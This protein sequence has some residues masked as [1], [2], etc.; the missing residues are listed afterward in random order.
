M[1]A[2]KRPLAP[3]TSPPWSTGG[4]TR[5][6][7][8]RYSKRE[9]PRR[10][11]IR[12]FPFCPDNFVWLFLDIFPDRCLR[13]RAR[14]NA[15]RLQGGV[16]GVPAAAQQRLFQGGFK[17][18][19]RGQVKREEKRER[20]K[21]TVFAATFFTCPVKLAT[22]DE[23]LSTMR[24]LIESNQIWIGF[25]DGVFLTGI[26]TMGGGRLELGE[27]LATS[28]STWVH[29]VSPPILWFYFY[30]VLSWINELYYIY[31]AG[32]N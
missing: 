13:E 20:E 12:S 17:V 18:P 8:S 9:E 32:P 11:P 5:S 4:P 29:T 16:P 28:I 19:R 26:I 10:Q 23:H 25:D 15:E 14:G 1:I 24:V 3:T 22:K 27:F 2:R 6:W 31:L 7:I 30:Y 21:K